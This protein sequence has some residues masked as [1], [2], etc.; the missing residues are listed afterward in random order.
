[1]SFTTSRL[2]RLAGAEA[3]RLAAR[4]RS[5]EAIR[6]AQ[7]GLRVGHAL[8]RADNPVLA[9][10]M[11]ALAAQRLSLLALDDVTRADPPDLA[12]AQA[13]VRELEASRIPPE[14][15]QRVW[16]GEYRLVKSVLAT[17]LAEPT[18]SREAPSLTRV[19]PHDFL[20]HP[21]RTLALFAER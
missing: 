13:L 5:A 21:N 16:A 17:H 10:A 3:R 8:V 20:Y 15:W 18:W 4:G 11:I 1:M 12:R 6:T 7:V 14:A 9:D 2:A 19:V